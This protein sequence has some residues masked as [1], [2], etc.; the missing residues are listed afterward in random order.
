VLG[1]GKIT[2]KMTFEKLI[3]F[4]NVL[5]VADI[6]KNLVHG[7]LLRKKCFKMI[8]KNDKFIPSK[9]IMFIGQGVLVITISKYND[10]CNQE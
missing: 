1:V 7:S 5:C 9:N 4:N 3:T 8:F 10:H 2:L 6:R